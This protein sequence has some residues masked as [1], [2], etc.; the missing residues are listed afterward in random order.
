MLENCKGKQKVDGLKSSSV[1]EREGLGRR[2][3]RSLIKFCFL[4]CMVDP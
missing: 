2:Y 3:P 4:D 1:V